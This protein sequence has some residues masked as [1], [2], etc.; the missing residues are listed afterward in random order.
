[1][2]FHIAYPLFVVAPPSILEFSPSSLPFFHNNLFFASRALLMGLWGGLRELFSRGQFGYPLLKDRSIG[3]K[4]DLR[5]GCI[6]CGGNGLRF[7][8]VILHG[9]SVMEVHLALLLRFQQPI[10]TMNPD[11]AFCPFD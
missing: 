3:K 5:P 8:P 4:S 1:M 11:L 2:L 10:A 7:E 6:R 9:R